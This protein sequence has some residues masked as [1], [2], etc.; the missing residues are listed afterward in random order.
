[1]KRNQ[2][3]PQTT[4]GQCFTGIQQPK[5]WKRPK[6]E[7]RRERER[8]STVGEKVDAKMIP[9]TQYEMTTHS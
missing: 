4:H 5:R 7:I 2:V 6:V 8:E 1:M 9:N 3:Y